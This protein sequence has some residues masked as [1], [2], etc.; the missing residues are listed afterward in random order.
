MERR[1]LLV[2]LDRIEADLVRLQSRLWRVRRHL[3][4]TWGLRVGHQ[5]EEG[6]TTGPHD[7]RGEG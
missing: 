3:Q 5:Y 6:P 7:A 4:D 1:E 2:T